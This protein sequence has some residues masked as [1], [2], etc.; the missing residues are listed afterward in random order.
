MAGRLRS[1]L[2][3]SRLKALR[4][5]GLPC[6]IPPPYQRS[7][8]RQPRDYCEIQRPRFPVISAER[9]TLKSATRSSKLNSVKCE[10]WFHRPMGSVLLS[11]SL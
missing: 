10:D 2:F 9:Y 5:G 4:S 3:A 1:G 7:P 8:L 6:G 11:N